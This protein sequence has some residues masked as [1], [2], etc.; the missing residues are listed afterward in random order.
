MYIQYGLVMVIY[1][2]DRGAVSGLSGVDSFL[3]S[4]VGNVV[5]PKIGT[6]HTFIHEGHS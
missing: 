3:D 2:R 6:H 1:C 5:I 4:E